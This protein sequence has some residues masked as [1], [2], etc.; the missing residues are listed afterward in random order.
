MR[1]I[2]CLASRAV[3]GLLIACVRAYQAVLSPHIGTCCRFEPTCSAYC[4]EALRTHGV[5]R[6]CWLAFLRILRCRPFGPSG[7]DPVPPKKGC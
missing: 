4:I 3:S 6:G 5:V 1:K 7:Y 2:L